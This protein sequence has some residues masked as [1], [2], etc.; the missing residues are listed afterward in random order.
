MAIVNTNGLTPHRYSGTEEDEPT[1]AELAGVTDA[2]LQDSRYFP[3]GNGGHATVGVSTYDMESAHLPKTLITAGIWVDFPI[4]KIP[5]NPLIHT[6]TIATNI[7]SGPH[8]RE[9]HTDCVIR[10]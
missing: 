7:Q 10:V 9:H 4:E 1:G 2:S 5:D 3:L 8:I 6:H